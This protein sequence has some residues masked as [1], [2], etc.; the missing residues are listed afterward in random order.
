MNKTKVAKAAAA[1]CGMC[2]ATVGPSVPKMMACSR[3]GSLFYCSKLCQKQHWAEHKLECFT[4]EERRARTAV[5]KD[6]TVTL[7]TACTVALARSPFVVAPV[8]EGLRAVQ[9]DCSEH[10][11]EAEEVQAV[12]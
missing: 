5:A 8:G 12:P 3:C 7:C 10:R 2:A 1:C 6:T 9:E 11:Q 4:S